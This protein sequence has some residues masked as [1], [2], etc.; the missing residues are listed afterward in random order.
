MPASA[1]PGSS[2][3]SISACWPKRSST[4]A[5]KAVPKRAGGRGRARHRP[6]QLAREGVGVVAQARHRGRRQAAGQRQVDRGGAL[7]ARLVEQLGE[8]VVPLGDLR[9]LDHVEALVGRGAV[10]GADQLG[11]GQPAARL[12][13]GPRHRPGAGG[14]DVVV[15]VGR[16][17]GRLLQPAL[18]RLAPL[19]ELVAHD[20]L[21]GRRAEGARALAPDVGGDGEVVGGAGEG[22]VAQAQLLLRVV[23][24]G[25]RAVGLEG[26]LVVAD[27]L[28]LV[29]AVAAQRRGQHGRRRGPEGARAVAG[30]AR[31]PH[32][33]AEDR[34]P[35]QP[36]GAVDG[37]QLDR[38][39]RGG[40][41]DVEAVALVVLGGEVG[42]QRGQRDVAVD[43]LELRDRLDEEV[44]VV[45][46]RG[47]RRRGRRR[48]LDVDAGRV[49]DAAD[50]V[51]QRVADV[52]AQPAQLAG[53]EGEPVERLGRVRRVAGRLDGVAERGQLGG[54]D[55]VGDL[56]QLVGDR[57]RLRA[58]AYAGDLR[59]AH[60]EQAQVARADRPPRAGEEGEHRGVGGDVVQ[61]R[62]RRDDLGH[63]RQPDQTGQADDLDRDAR[64]GQRVV[65]VLGLRVVAAQHADLG[66]RGA[67]LVHAADLVGE[68]GQLV[69]GPL[70]DV[71]LD[72][73]LPRDLGR[74]QPRD[75]V[76]VGLEQRLGE[77]V[78]DVEDASV[79]AP[80]DRQRQAARLAVG[81]R[82]GLGEVEDVG[83]RGAAPAVDRLVGVAHRHHRVAEA[84]L[85]V[86]AGEQ[87]ATASWPGRPRCPGTR[88][89]ARP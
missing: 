52:G 25:R 69:D 79:G 85:G 1:R 64:G 11:G 29:G 66:P 9:G 12:L 22:D 67:G 15:G 77:P 89:A 82:E 84:V 18:D 28:R 35:L 86:G 19:L 42:Q 49:D 43:G 48:Q 31:L 70:E 30:E 61:E 3:G 38:V 14:V 53:E 56:E 2:S 74:A 34:R 20:A 7:G 41:R 60:R 54:V 80:V 59:R 24:L 39:G 44:E 51:E 8:V 63:L 81:G 27:E 55:A 78:G 33:D 10:D 71:G 46:A 58:T 45:A 5:W 6:G 26:G 57:R 68:P 75:L 65:D 37:E 62:Q 13:A 50:H 32:A 40:G 83:D 88:R 47:S 73:A 87:P 16:L 76:A 17:R 36:L 4:Q 72:V 23:G 21:V